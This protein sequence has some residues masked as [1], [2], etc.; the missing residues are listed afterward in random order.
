MQFEL[1][2]RQVYAAILREWC[3]PPPT[4]IISYQLL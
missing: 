3:Y 1:L 4:I 2:F